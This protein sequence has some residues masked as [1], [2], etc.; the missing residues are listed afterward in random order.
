MSSENSSKTSL[1]TIVDFCRRKGFVFPSSEIYGG[2]A[3]T[4]DF[5]SLGVLLK[6]NL[7]KAWRD[8]MVNFRTDT[9]EIE[10]A[11]FLHPKV[12]EASGHIGGFSDLL[13]EDLVTHKRYRADHLIEEANLPTYNLDSINN[14]NYK[15][16]Y[17]LTLKDVK[18]ADGIDIENFL[19]KFPELNYEQ[20]KWYY[21]LILFYFD[22][23]NFENRTP[24]VSPLKLLANNLDYEN[25]VFTFKKNELKKLLEG[26]KYIQLFSEYYQG[27]FPDVNDSKYL[28]EAIVEG[29]YDLYFTDENST[30]YRAIFIDEPNN[31]NNISDDAGSLTAE[32]IDK[33]I[34]YYNLKSPEGNLLSKAKKFNLLVK[35]HLGP[36]EDESTV[37]YLK[38][39]ACQ[40][41][42]VNWKSV[43][44]TTRRK[45]P[46]GIAQMGKAFRNEITVKQFMF[47]TREFEQID[48]QYFVKPGTEKEWFEYWRQYRYDFYTKFLG[49]N[50]ANLNWH[51]HGENELVFYA[52]EA[53]DIY[54]RFGELGFKEMEGVHNR[55]DYDTKQH[56]KFSGT[57]LTYLDPETNQRYLPYIV[58]MSL[59]INR[60][61]LSA[62]FEFYKEETLSDGDKRVVLQLP[63]RLAPYKY[64]ILPLMK[65]DG[66]A[67]KATEIYADLRKKGISC[68]YDEAGSIGKRYRRQDE[69]GTPFCI[70][71]DYQTIEDNTVTI[72]DRD[73]MEQKRVKIEELYKINP[74]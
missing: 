63:V 54:Y 38:G 26:E 73:T 55:T 36:V 64:A 40:N 15:K 60:L 1:K 70:C 17:K 46:F 19:Q 34:E 16:Q 11:I 30:K 22:Y 48:M 49:Y 33:L 74:A 8:W 58:E 24:S 43:Q 39:E 53:W 6:K 20:R 65:K 9:V 66:L 13:V 7:E 18:L 14:S 69:N 25:K 56:S 61:F 51:Q 44:E 12:W 71:V 50:S 41:I 68:D 42:Y 2:Y 28:V 67:E 31:S 72:R 5:G 62:L 59:G 47:R 10:G 23:K 37:A 3:A 27:G 35:T 21:D 45:L 29:C 4:Y 32:E 57:D 52:S